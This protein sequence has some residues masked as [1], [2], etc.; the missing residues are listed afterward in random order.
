MASKND[1]YVQRTLRFP[2]AY[3][4][5]IEVYADKHKLCFSEAVRELCMKGLSAD[6][7]RETA[8]RFSELVDASVDGAVSRLENAFVFLAD[9][10]IYEMRIIAHSQ[11][12]H[13]S[14][15]ED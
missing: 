8:S 11:S 2:A 13:E 15:M 3:I 6:F 7:E 1:V 9:K 14:K 4:T 10:M 5:A 12:P